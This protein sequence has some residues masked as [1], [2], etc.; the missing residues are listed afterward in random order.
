MVLVHSASKLL[1]KMNTDEAKAERLVEELCQI[2]VEKLVGVVCPDLQFASIPYR[3][4]LVFPSPC[5]P[6][7]VALR[8]DLESPS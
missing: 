6:E 7:T 1:A 4:T 8:I 5:R 3:R 2:P